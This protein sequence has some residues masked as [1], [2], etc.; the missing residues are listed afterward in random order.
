[1]SEIETT[2][3]QNEY[4][5]LVELINKLDYQYYVLDQPIKSDFEYDKL[6]AKLIEIERDNP[7][8]I[9][10]NSPSKRVGGLPLDSFVKVKHRS[11]ML[12]LSNS[13]SIDDIISFEEKILKSLDQSESIEFF[14]EPKFDGLALELVYEHGN[15]VVASTRGDGSTGE[16]VTQN[17]LTIRS[18]PLRIEALLNIPI[19]EIRGEVLIYKEDFLLLNQE[20]EESGLPIF[21]NPRNAAAGTIRQL[22]PKIANK[23]PLRFFAYGLG[24]YQ[25]FPL[26][27]QSEIYQL[28]KTF[29]FSV[30]PVD[31]C[32]VFSNLKDISS[33]YYRIQ[34]IRSQL[35]FEIDGIVIK[36]NSLHLQNELGLV[37]RSPRWATAAKFPPERASTIIENIII[38]VGRTGALTPVAIM[39]P[40]KVGGVTITQATLHNQD[41][42]NRKDIRIGD[43]VWVQRA[44]DV[45]PEITEVILNERPTNSQPFE[46]PNICPTCKSQVEKID[47]EAIIRC[48]NK[49]C[50]SALKESFKHYVSR[51]ALN[52]EKIGD[53]LVETL[54]DSN[55]VCRFADFYKLDKN[56]LLT[57]DRMGEKSVSNILES[58]EK[59][60]NTTFARFIYGLG[61]R[62][63]GEQTAKN[64]SSHYSSIIQLSKAKVDDLLTITDIG[65]RVANSIIETLNDITQLKDFIELEDK[66]LNFDSNHKLL[67]TKL[68]GK[69]FVITGTLTLPRE[70]VSA[71]IESHG[72]KIISS[73]SSKLNFI[74]VGDEPGSKLLKAQ[75]LNISILSWGELLAML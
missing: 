74:I 66:Y 14:I 70:Q 9:A 40:V 32:G 2:L 62:F 53:K 52:I 30:S 21:A 29:G 44:G 38:Q 41:E 19:F 43:Q 3:D 60:R 55:L 37:A 24:V 54:V 59:S 73:V 46:I 45:I 72:G 8:W 56:K 17:I 58:I 11:Q 36:V 65:P 34:Q 1:M 26:E 47:G 10:K 25:N 5:K 64:L 75:K 57:L 68:K 15:L 27:T 23:R 61:I 67:S 39:K 42:I 20:Q 7:E 13:Y 49:K 4:L 16:D 33:F 63:V 31:L 50:P 6:W 12:S 51:R 35:K 22:D 18:I 48:S 69:T 71:L 28:L